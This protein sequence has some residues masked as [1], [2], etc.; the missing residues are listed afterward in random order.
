MIVI[1]SNVFVSSLGKPDEFTEGSKKFFK[2][3]KDDVEILL[4]ALVMIET[5]VAIY[6]QNL[7]AVSKILK[8]FHGFKIVPLDLNFINLS[9]PF[10]PKN[11]ILKTSDLTI[12][13]TAKINGA[14]LITWDNKLL[15]YAGTICEVYSPAQILTKLSTR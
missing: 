14:T 15:K 12:A 10:L 6:K 5:I 7:L 4:P 13:I 9:V 11:N 1:D 2:K 8:Y 3:L